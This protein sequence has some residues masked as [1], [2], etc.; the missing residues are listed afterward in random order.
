MFLPYC[1]ASTDRPH[2]NMTVSAV[3]RLFITPGRWTLVD[4]YSGCYRQCT[5]L[6]LARGLGLYT[7]TSVKFFEEHIYLAF[8]EPTVGSESEQTGLEWTI[9]VGHGDS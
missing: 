2:T 6:R 7:C 9:I 5:S 3:A 1:H 4:R 8:I